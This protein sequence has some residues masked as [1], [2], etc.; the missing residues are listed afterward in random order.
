MAHNTAVLLLIVLVALSSTSITICQANFLAEPVLR[1]SLQLSGTSND[2]TNTG[3]GLAGRGLRRGNGMTVHPGGNRLF[4]TA[5][6]GSL[7]VVQ[8]DQARPSTSFLY[9]PIPIEATERYYVECRSSVTLVEE[10]AVATAE[11]AATEEYLLYAVLD[12]PILG[13]ND[14]IVNQDGI[15][16]PAFD[17]L[18]RDGSSRVLAVN[19][20]G[21][22]R[23]S[24]QVPG[25]IQ[26]NPVVGRSGIYVS[27]NVDGSGSL[28]VIMVN[29]NN[30]GEGVS[31]EVV[32]TLVGTDEFGNTDAPLGPPAIQ[33]PLEEDEDSTEDIVLVAENWDQG[34]NTEQGRLYMLTRT[35]EFEDT[36]GRGNES[37]ELGTIST[38]PFSSTVPPVV[39]RNSV[40][41]A[42]AGANLAGYTGLGGI[43]SGRFTEIDPRWVYQAEPSPRNA[44]QRK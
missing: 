22:L 10:E 12:T 19:L 25:R 4:V 37:Y 33:P 36:G 40:F 32:A 16:V 39:V 41:L 35:T 43:R 24:V 20:D 8:V 26:G 34:Y 42:A 15:V 2:D 9:Q 7:H 11:G 23:W 18:D 17:N 3:E 27:H 30:N 38:W 14:M 21:S 13:S 44:S 1:W 28:S 29:N 31:A 6:D 5:D